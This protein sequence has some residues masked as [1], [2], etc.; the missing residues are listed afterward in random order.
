M[1]TSRKPP[2]CRLWRLQL[3][4]IQFDDAIDVLLHLSTN[5]AAFENSVD[6]MHQVRA[7]GASAILIAWRVSGWPRNV[8]LRMRFFESLVTTQRGATAI[9]EAIQSGVEMLEP[10]AN[11]NPR[12]D[13]RVVLLTDGQNNQ[14]KVTALDAF[15]AANRIGV[16]VG[17]ATCSPLT[18]NLTHIT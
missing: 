15:R 9:Y 18:P 8:L 4:L 2:A 11:A 17:R 13:L 12:A 1:V 6:T 5:L 16:V 10:V 7:A 14:T 3:G